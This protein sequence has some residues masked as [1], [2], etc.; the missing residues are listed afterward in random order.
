MALADIF[1][2]TNATGRPGTH[3]VAERGTAGLA[4]LLDYSGRYKRKGDEIFDPFVRYEIPI[5]EL[6]QAVKD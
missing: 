6:G 3:H 4:V 1:P 5:E 2:G